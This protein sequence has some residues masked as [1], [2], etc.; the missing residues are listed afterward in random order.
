MNMGDSIHSGH[1]ER[2]RRE[3]LKNGF[4]EAT[5]PHK[6]IEMLLFYSIPRKDTNEIAHELLNRFG[7]ISGILD[8]PVERL[9]EVPGVNINTAALIKLIIPI[10]RIYRSD[11]CA[12]AEKFSS[13][14]DICTYLMN[15]YFGYD[16]EVFSVMSI[17]AGG[18]LIGYDILSVGNVSEVNISTREVIETVLKRRAACAVIAHNHPDGVALPSKEDI[19][20][21]ETVSSALSHINVKLLDH[22]VISGDDYVSMAQSRCFKYIFGNND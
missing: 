17:S 20:V 3:F 2:V 8:A 4:T 9:T 10:A 19:A 1:R 21:T 18:K 6:I 15:K 13:M 22:I 11:K 5:P 7:S 12:A 14:D 16:K